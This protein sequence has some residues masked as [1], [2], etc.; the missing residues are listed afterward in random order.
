ME[1]EEILEVKVSDLGFSK[2]IK[3][4]CEKM[5]NILL[6]LEFNKDEKVFV[7]YI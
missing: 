2:D 6:K 7:V 1:D 4:W 5:N 3:L